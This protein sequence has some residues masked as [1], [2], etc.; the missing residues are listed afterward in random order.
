MMRGLTKVYHF[1]R[2]GLFYRG[3]FADWGGFGCGLW[4][5]LPRYHSC[6][7]NGA[8]V[9]GPIGLQ[10]QANGPTKGVV[11][12]HQVAT[13]QRQ[14]GVDRRL[15]SYLGCHYW[16]QRG[17]CLQA[18]GHCRRGV[19]ALGG[20]GSYLDIRHHFSQRGRGLGQE[21]RPHGRPAGS[22]HHLTFGCQIR[23]VRDVTGPSR[24]VSGPT[25]G[26]TFTIRRYARVRGGLTYFRRGKTGVNYKGFEVVFGRV[27]SSILRFF[28]VEGHLQRTRRGT[29]RTRKIRHRHNTQGS[30]TFST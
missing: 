13:F 26:H 28:G 3:L 25:F 18:R 27:G 11:G 12:C 29:I 5:S 2:V 23:V 24:Q 8:S 19:H 6:T 20:H 4:G 30:G 15:T 22:L 14:G 1:L 9:C 10:T 21:F 7:R 17:F 16:G